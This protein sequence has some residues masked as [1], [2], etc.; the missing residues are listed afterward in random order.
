M[1]VFFSFD[2]TIYA[3]VTNPIDDTVTEQNFTCCSEINTVAGTI[4]NGSLSS[5][6][7]I[8]ASLKSSLDNTDIIQN[9][10]ETINGGLG[11]LHT[12]FAFVFFWVFFIFFFC[13]QTT[14]NKKH[15]K[16]KIK[17]HY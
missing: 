12:H 11:M 1:F 13:V 3:N 8:G 14:N 5:L 15:N 17:V 10:R 4:A 2:F 7:G 9:A 16:I 6:N